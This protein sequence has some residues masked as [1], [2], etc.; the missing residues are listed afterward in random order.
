MQIYNDAAILFQTAFA[1]P[2]LSPPSIDLYGNCNCN[3]EPKL[4][5]KKPT[6]HENQR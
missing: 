4:H 5:A 1:R 2:P 3:E 6:E